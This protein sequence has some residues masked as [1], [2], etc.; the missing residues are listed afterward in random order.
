[1]AKGLACDW[2]KGCE[3][4]LQL[5]KEPFFLMGKVLSNTKKKKT[6]GSTLS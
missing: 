3:K 1:M 5:K 6:L 4:V 2:W